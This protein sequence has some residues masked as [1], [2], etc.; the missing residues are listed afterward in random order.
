ML[1]PQN[2]KQHHIFCFQSQDIQNPN[3][4]AD[5]PADPFWEPAP[6]WNIYNREAE[7]GIRIDQLI[8][9]SEDATSKPPS[10]ADASLAFLRSLPVV[11]FD[12][13]AEESKTCPICMEA[14]ENTEHPEVPVRLPCSHIFGKSCIS[15]WISNNSCPL[16]RA[17]CFRSEAVTAPALNREV[18]RPSPAIRALSRLH[19]D[20]LI[21]YLESSHVAAR[22]ILNILETRT[23]EL[24]GERR[25][26]LESRTSLGAQDGAS[27]AAQIEM[28]LR[29]NA[30]L[31]GAFRQ[32]RDRRLQDLG[33]V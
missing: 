12:D 15:K 30:A 24:D 14:F 21:W 27:S 33:S 16:C 28:S 8:T 3:S 32:E 1:H 19:P 25:R 10:T 7:I 6:F 13:L 29:E 23:R 26:L 22:D 20:T 9:E 11:P 4:M 17:V 31:A 5:S 2:R 18:N